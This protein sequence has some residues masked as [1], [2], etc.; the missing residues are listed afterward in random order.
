MA[1]QFT[2]KTKDAESPILGAKFWRRGMKLEGTV[3][4]SF[5]TAN[6][7]CYE[8][9]T[10]EPITVNGEKTKLVSVGALKGFQMALAAAGLAELERGD[11]AAIE[12]TG[13]TGT[14]KGN[15]RVD[16]AISVLRP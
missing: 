1:Q 3:T 14:E 4:R 8:I 13:T 7:I 10:K 11:K 6:G 12:C 5:E 2:G 15:P 9:S 16:F